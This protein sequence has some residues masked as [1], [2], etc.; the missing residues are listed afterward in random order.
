MPPFEIEVKFYLSDLPAFEQKLQRMGAVQAHPRVHEVN[1]R[2]DLPD[3]SL[4]K[5]GRVL[6]LRQDS[7]SYYTFKGPSEVSQGV[8]ARREVEL[9]VPDFDEAKAF[10]EALGYQ[11]TV[12]YEK[13][14][15][16]YHF[17]GVLITLD[18]M[19][20]GTLCELEGPDPETIHTAA[21]ALGLDWEE[22]STA[23]YLQLF[24]TLKGLMGLTARNLS[25]AE[26][27]GMSFSASDLGL[28]PADY[29]DQS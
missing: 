9:D 3:G 16:G 8:N 18:E 13:Y 4:S 2:F 10:L 21:D 6:R 19:P 1:L 28:H 26:L 27:D 11:V 23:S 22:R 7:H 15:T 24:E 5:A 20:F 14:R 17:Q 25:F 12:M 29:S